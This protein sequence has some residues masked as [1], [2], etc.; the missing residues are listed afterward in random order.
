M[1]YGVAVIHPPQVRTAAPAPVFV[2]HT[3]RR[4]QALRITGVAAAVGMI[5]ALGSLVASFFGAT[6]AGLPAWPQKSGVG[7]RGVI[8][9]SV[10]PASS[11]STHRIPAS[12]TTSMSTPQPTTTPT[13]SPTKPGPSGSPTRSHPH[14]SK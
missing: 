10:H 8:T 11:T 3:G 1:V 12:R 9:G 14:K 4:G 13:P 7:A 2:D 5:V 6:P